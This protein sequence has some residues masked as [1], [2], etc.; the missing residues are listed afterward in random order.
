L[1]E[2]FFIEASLELKLSRAKFP[3]VMRS[4]GIIQKTHKLYQIF[5]E[6]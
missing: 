5:D 3:I 6:L 2:A 4:L 1:K